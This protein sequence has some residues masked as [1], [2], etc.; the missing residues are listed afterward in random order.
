[1]APEYW[2][3]PVGGALVAGVIYGYNALVKMRNLVEGAW[4][5]V[6]VQLKRRSDLVPELVEITKG[7]RAF[8]RH[9]L[10]ELTRLRSQLM[11]AKAT[12]PQQAQAESALRLKLKELVAVAEAYPELRANTQFLK[13]QRQLTETEDLIASARRYYNAAVRD[14]NTL[15]ESFPLGL[16]G[17]LLGFRPRDFF[18]ATE[19][20]KKTPRARME[21]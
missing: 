12:P 6:E 17:N 3:L 13:L 16:I 11:D 5:D 19:E 15:I 18:A 7:Y 1:M 9:T 21:S 2:I 8:E 14:Y 20:E 4:S 10:E